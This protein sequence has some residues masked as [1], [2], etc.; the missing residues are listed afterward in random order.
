MV[1]TADGEFCFHRET[2]GDH[3]IAAGD[4]LEIW[5]LGLGSI[6]FG[7]TVNGRTVFRGYQP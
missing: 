7:L 3:A 4:A 2:L 5:H 1:T 6:V